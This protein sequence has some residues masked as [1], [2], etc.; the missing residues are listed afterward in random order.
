VVKFDHISGHFNL[1]SDELK[2]RLSSYQRGKEK[3]KVGIS[4]DPETRWTKH[5]RSQHQWSKMV[6]LYES[7]SHNIIGQAETELIQY[8]QDR[9]PDS[10]QNKVSGGGGINEPY[11]YEKFY[12]YLLLK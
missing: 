4:V 12:L 2:R 8:S 10:C 5:S 3:F 11:L 9:F 6:V 7:S 1:V